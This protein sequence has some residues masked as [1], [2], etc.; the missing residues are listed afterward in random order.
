MDFTSIS[1]KP[2]QNRWIGY[3]IKSLPM[4]DWRSFVQE[5]YYLQF[6]YM[7]TET[8]GE[9]HIELT[10]K[11]SNQK[12]YQSVMKL[13]DKSQ[14]FMLRLNDYKDTI[15]DWKFVDEI[16]FVFFPENCIGQKGSVFISNL[17]INKD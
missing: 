6:N 7:A 17:S 13:N 11:H 15:I 8:I 12:I 3:S 2:E 16:C 5:D 14:Q 10:N 4:R 9:I 1:S